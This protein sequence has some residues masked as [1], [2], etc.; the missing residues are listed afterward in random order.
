MQVLFWLAA[1]LL[2]ATAVLVLR[3]VL[4]PFL[5]GI[6]IAYALNPIADRLER[7]GLPRMAA[8]A[9][10]V[11]VAMLVLVLVLMFLLPLLVGQL[12]QLV[13]SLPGEI[14]RLKDLIE[15]W[16]RDRLGPRF[17]EFQS[18]LDKA[19]GD[20]AGNWA[21]LA[22]AIATSLWNQGRALV[23]FLSLLLITPL[24]VFYLLVDWRQMLAKIDSWLPRSHAATVRRLAGEMD[25]AI[26]AFIRGQGFVC[27]VLGTLYAVG[28][29]LI[30]VR[31]GL[32]I[33]IA[34]GILSFV[35]FVGWAVGLMLSAGL[36][37]VQFWPGQG[38]LWLVLGLFALGQAIDTAVLSPKI[39]GTQIGLH[40]VWLI[41]ALAVFSYLFGFVGIL[42]AV[43]LA[44]AAGVLVRFALELYL[45]SAIYT[46]TPP[47]GEAGMPG[48]G[49]K[50]AG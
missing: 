14:E 12:Q 27:I 39:V 31:Y 48:G 37:I 21:A 20:L 6:V 47:T 7:L 2:A 41:F 9:L 50:T 10:I 23:G 36:A 35:P 3:D 42:V 34:T 43:P 49:A 28:L 4:L 40:P 8:A 38:P 25:R 19:L 44:A 45:G 15:G 32:L 18:G 11:A 16:A 26:A 30:G 1:G 24:V 33:G 29:S 13:V 46:G 17:A 5:A 22:G